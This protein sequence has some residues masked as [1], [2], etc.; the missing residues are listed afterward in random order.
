MT[1]ATEYE[2]FQQD[3][4]DLKY[5]LVP[6]RDLTAWDCITLV[7]TSLTDADVDA[8]ISITNY[9]LSQST[10]RFESQMI[11]ALNPGKYFMVTQMYNSTTSQRK[12]IHERLVVKQ[13][14]VIG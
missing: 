7:K 5:G 6:D 11:A 8:L 12:E 4:M 2:I 13:Q 1:I 14:G 10:Y 3:S 9:Q